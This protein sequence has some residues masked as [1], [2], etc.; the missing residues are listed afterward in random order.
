DAIR[1]ASAAGGAA[2][3]RLGASAALPKRRAIEELYAQ[4]Y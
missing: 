1:W 3:R 2:V 4:T